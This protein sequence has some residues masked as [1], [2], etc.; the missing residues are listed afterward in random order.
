MFVCLVK[1]K[2]KDWPR[3]IGFLLISQTPPPC[4]SPPSRQTVSWFTEF[5][6]ISVKSLVEFD[7]RSWKFHLPSALS[8]EW[9]SKMKRQKLCYSLR[10]VNKTT[11]MTWRDEDWTSTQRPVLGNW[12][13]Y[14]FKGQP[15]Y[16]FYRNG[17][18]WK[19]WNVKIFPQRV[20]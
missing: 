20:N 18:T 9:V 16:S 5:S 14:V 17:W 2:I 13:N 15:N 19:I 7:L 6:G 4:R 10:V 3:R 12:K 8:W 1:S 11:R